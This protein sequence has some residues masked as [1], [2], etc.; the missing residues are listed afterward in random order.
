MLFL[1]LTIVF[2]AGAQMHKLGL[3]RS[4]DNFHCVGGDA[5]HRTASVRTFECYRLYDGDRQWWCHFPRFN[6][7]TVVGN[8]SVECN[9]TTLATG[10]CR[11]EY[12]LHTM[13]DWQVIMHIIMH[14]AVDSITQLADIVTFS[15][16][17]FWLMTNARPNAVVNFLPELKPIP[18]EKSIG[19]YFFGY[20]A[21][22]IVGVIV[23]VFGMFA[24]SSLWSL[25]PKTAVKSRTPKKTSV[26][27][28]SVPELKPGTDLNR[29]LPENAL[30]TTTFIPKALCNEMTD[31]HRAFLVDIASHC[32]NEMVGRGEVVPITLSFERTQN[33]KDESFIEVTLNVV[34]PKKTDITS[35]HLTHLNDRFQTEIN[36][37]VV[38]VAGDTIKLCIKALL[39]LKQCEPGVTTV[40][41][42]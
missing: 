39:P 37:V 12:A 32:A 11:V 27:T 17:R 38:S 5:C 8:V 16:F 26:K 18:I 6:F 20:L 24:T 28:V 33:V 1:L 34:L 19:I 21:G 9:I 31:A 41:N 35:N 22:V 30:V 13:T 14:I 4:S 23:S 2:L 40:D 15:N 3:V 7:Q 36:A 25:S 29:D 42:K 10:Q